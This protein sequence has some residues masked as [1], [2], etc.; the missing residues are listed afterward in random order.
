MS[1]KLPRF[2]S[3]PEVKEMFRVASSCPRDAILL[4][5]MFHLGLRNSEIANLRIEDVDLINSTIK[6]VQGK[7]KKDRLIPIPSLFSQE[8][9]S[10]I[11]QRSKGLLLEGRAG[12]GNISDRHIRRIVKTYA[13]LAGIRQFEEVHP[14]TL[15][16]SYAT[17]LHNRSVP[18]NEIQN[19]LGHKNIETTT[20]YTHLGI[21]NLK[22]SI[23]MAFA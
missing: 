7:G 11:G 5:S 8:L 10:F 12:D 6:V 17:F 15:R 16:H 3:P 1:R 19:L 4:K 23:D 18:L 22:R 20:I 14:H 2:L 13:K 9:K 21:D